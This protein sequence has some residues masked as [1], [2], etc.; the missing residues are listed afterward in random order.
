MYLIVWIVLGMLKCEV[1][2]LVIVWLFVFCIYFCSV[3]V[4]MSLWVGFVLRCVIVF[5]IEVLGRILFVM[6]VCLVIMWVSFL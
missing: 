1:V 3:L 6:V 5:L 4:L 2:S